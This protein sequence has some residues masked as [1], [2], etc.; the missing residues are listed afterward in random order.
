MEK[1]NDLSSI[2]YMAIN[3]LYLTCLESIFNQF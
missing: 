3:H 2:S 1:Y